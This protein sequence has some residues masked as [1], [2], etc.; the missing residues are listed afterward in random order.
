M[1]QVF[2]TMG[3]LGILNTITKLLLPNFNYGD[4]IFSYL[5]ALPFMSVGLLSWSTGP[6]LFLWLFDGAPLWLAIAI[7]LYYRK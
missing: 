5:F 6:L 1:Y 3:V 4:G 2:I 7:F